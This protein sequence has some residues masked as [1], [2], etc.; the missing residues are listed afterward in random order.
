MPHCPNCASQ[1]DIEPAYK[2]Y[3]FRGVFVRGQGVRCRNCDTILEFSQWRVLAVKFI[4]CLL[5]VPFIWYRDTTVAMRIVIV[6]LA[7][8]PLLVTTFRCFPDLFQ[9][10]IPDPKRKVSSDDELR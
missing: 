2:A 10:R 8:G 6:T 9:L 7:V 4:P 1:V 3:N 5:L